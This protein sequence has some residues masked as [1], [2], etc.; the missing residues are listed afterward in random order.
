MFLETVNA[1]IKKIGKTQ[2]GVANEMGMSRSTLL[3]Y[4]T[5]ETRMTD[6]IASDLSVV[7]EMPEFTMFFCVAGCKIGRQYC[8][9][10]LNNVNLDPVATLTKYRQE[11]KEFANVMDE[12]A[13]LLLNKSGADDCTAEEIA[14]IERMAH[15]MLDVE[16]VIETMKKELWRFV[17]VAGLIAEHN[18]KCEQKKYVDKKKPGLK[19][20]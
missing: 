5:G 3:R 14:H 19:I 9:P 13:D 1:Q 2:E 10:L 18:S 12:M 4:L 6:E 7:I 17:N 15:E 11:A 20:N 8:Y 16:H